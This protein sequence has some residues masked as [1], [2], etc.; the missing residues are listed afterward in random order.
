MPTPASQ[1]DEQ[2]LASPVPRDRV[3]VPTEFWSRSLGLSKCQS[4][5]LA[6]ALSARQ[7]PPPDAP[8]QTRQCFAV[9]SGDTTRAVRR[10]AVLFVAPEKAVTPGCVAS[11]FGP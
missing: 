6:S 4:G 8:V 7:M 9:Q 11:V 1:P 5:S 10:L 2:R 3:S